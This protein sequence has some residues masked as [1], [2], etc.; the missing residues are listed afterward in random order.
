MESQIRLKCLRGFDYII[1]GK[2]DIDSYKTVSPIQSK[3]SRSRI[4]EITANCD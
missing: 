2:C 1:I 4:D 3:T